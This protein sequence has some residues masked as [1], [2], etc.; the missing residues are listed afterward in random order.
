MVRAQRIFRNI[1]AIGI[2]D[3]MNG[4]VL[5]PLNGASIVVAGVGPHEEAGVGA[6][7]QWSGIRQGPSRGNE[8]IAGLVRLHVDYGFLAA[9]DKAYETWKLVSSLLFAPRLRILPD[10][11]VGEEGGQ[12]LAETKTSAVRTTHLVAIVCDITQSPTKIVHCA[13][14]ERGKVNLGVILVKNPP[15]L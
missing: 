5:Q 8:R 6:A 12:S 15:S 3:A 10:V 1:L 13:L 4:E 11:S 7:R 9:A 14:A 2:G